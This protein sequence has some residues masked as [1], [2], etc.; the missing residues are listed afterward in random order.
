MLRRIAVAIAAVAILW[1]GPLSAQALAQSERPPGGRGGALPAP[2]QRPGL[3]PA[4]R[5]VPTERL[6]PREPAHA[7][8]VAPELVEKAVKDSIRALDLQTEFPRRV[9][10][11]RIAIP[12]EVIWIALIC[13][14]ALILFALREQ[15]VNLFRRTESG[16]EPPAAGAAEVAMGSEA[17][18]LAAADRL[19]REGNFVEA[20]HT[21]LLHSLAE[22]RRQLGERF[23]DS[24]TSR[25]I[26]RV[27]RLTATARAA[28]R[29]I[30]AAV[31]RTYFGAY[32][33][34]A[35]DYAACRQNFATLQQDLRGGAPA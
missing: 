19:S 18:A 20:M 4:P 21:L 8:A 30:V 27:A 32:P 10:P 7:P 29:E 5:P 3:P 17:D 11:V 14:A 2:T 31:E 33:A 23:A 9:E 1:P 26:L 13:A 25:E 12:P 15:I 16:W 22:I 34:Q 35:G 6:L 24:L 28:L